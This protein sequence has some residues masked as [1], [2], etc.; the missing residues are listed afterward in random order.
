MRAK[1]EAAGKLVAV[2]IDNTESE[3][4]LIHKT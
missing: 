1:R 3:P 2:R 4:S